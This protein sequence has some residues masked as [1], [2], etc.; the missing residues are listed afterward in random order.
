MIGIYKEIK[1]KYEVFQE[2]NDKK[3]VKCCKLLILISKVPGALIREKMMPLKSLEKSEFR[4]RNL[5][6]V[7]CTRLYKSLCRSVGLSDGRLVGWSVYPTLLFLR[8]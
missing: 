6:L 1:K 2:N 3:L 5:L 4:F 7:A 8:F